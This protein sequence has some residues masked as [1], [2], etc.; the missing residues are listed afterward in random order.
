MNTVRELTDLDVGAIRSFLADGRTE[1]WEPGAQQCVD[2]RHHSRDERE[3]EIAV[4]PAVEPVELQEAVDD[5]GSLNKNPKVTACLR[6][7]AR[8][9]PS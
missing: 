4:E 9:L 2:G 1:P 8:P 3:A 7:D 5:R 6:W